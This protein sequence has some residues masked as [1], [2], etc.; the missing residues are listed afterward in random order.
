[1]RPVLQHA[2][3]PAVREIRGNDR[4]SEV[5]QT[6]AGAGCIHDKPRLIERKRPLDIHD[7]HFSMALESPGVDSSAR[8]PNADATMGQQI[9]WRPWPSPLLQIRKCTHDSHPQLV[10]YRYS[11]HILRHFVGAS[12]TGVE[13]VSDNVGSAPICNNIYLHIGVSAQELKNDWRHHFSGDISKGFD[14]QRP[15]QGRSATARSLD[16]SAN[17]GDS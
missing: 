9:L 15:G 12:Y 8:Q 13:S 17:L 4:F 11:D 10:A 16:C 1:M 6:H 7:S 14:T 2:Y 5:C 3:K